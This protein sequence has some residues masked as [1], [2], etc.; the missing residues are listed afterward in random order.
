MQAPLRVILGAAVA[1]CAGAC[2]S[3]GDPA[4]A[5]GPGGSRSVDGGLDADDFDPVDADWKFPCLSGGEE[6]LVVQIDG[7][8]S[9]NLTTP[10]GLHCLSRYLPA[11]M[12]DS[13]LLD[14]DWVTTD[15]SGVSL[16]IRLPEFTPGR[17]GGA[18]PFGLT[19]VNGTDSWA[20]VPE[21]CR[22]TVESSEK[23]GQGATPAAEIYRVIGSVACDAGWAQDDVAAVLR[24]FVFTTRVSSSP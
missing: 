18:A 23:I 24:T 2:N 13:A 9:M 20:A 15:S 14:L 10:E 19:I 11:S 22:V 1:V 5:V 7:N 12:D 8:P 21:K 4:G 3:S 16:V 6:R 17:T